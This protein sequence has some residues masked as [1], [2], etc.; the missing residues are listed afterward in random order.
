MQC[1]RVMP[2]PEAGDEVWIPFQNCLIRLRQMRPRGSRAV[3][4]EDQKAAEAAEPNQG[5]S[6]TQQCWPRRL[7]VTLKAERGGVRWSERPL[8]PA[9][10]MVV[11]IAA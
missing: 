4:T 7:L 10:S 2:A 9:L 5:L 3:L 1:K 11:G 8:G 6:T